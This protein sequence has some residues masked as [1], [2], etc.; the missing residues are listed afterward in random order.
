MREPRRN[1]KPAGR[2]RPA[3]VITPREIQV[4]RLLCGSDEPA[5]K[6]LPGVL[7]LAEKTVQAHVYK[8]Y[9]KLGVRTRVGLVIKAI[10]MGWVACPCHGKR[11]EHGPAAP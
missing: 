1:R 7:G 5:L 11:G 8:L 4:C 9:R 10:E 6:A 2:P 3:P